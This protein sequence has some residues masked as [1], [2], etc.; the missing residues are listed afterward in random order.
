MNTL[1]WTGVGFLGLLIAIWLGVWLVTMLRS[2]LG[3]G[4]LLWLS[5]LVVI[6]WG[7]LGGIY[8]IAKAV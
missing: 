8:L 7:V 3:R 4:I 6:A 5:L 1:A 2:S